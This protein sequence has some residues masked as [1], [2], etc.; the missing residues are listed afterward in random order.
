MLFIWMHDTQSTTLIVFL[1]IIHR[2]IVAAEVRK[3]QLRQV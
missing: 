1:D 2:P 3:L